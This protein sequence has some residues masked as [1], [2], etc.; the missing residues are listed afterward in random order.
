MA[1]W[2]RL[3]AH[4]DFEQ[5]KTIYSDPFSSV[6]RFVCAEWIEEQI[7]TDYSVDIGID[8]YVKERSDNFIHSLSNQLE[9][10]I[11]EE[12]YR[13][14]E[15]MLLKYRIENAIRMFRE[16]MCNS[17]ETYRHIRNVMQSEQQFLDPQFGF[18]D[19]EADNINEKLRKLNNDILMS[20]VKQKQFNHELENYTS[21]ELEKEIYANVSEY[22]GEEEQLRMRSLDSLNLKN[23]ELYLTIKQIAV[24]LM[25][26]LGFIITEIEYVENTVISHRLGRLQRY[27]AFVA[28]GER[29]PLSELRQTEEWYSTLGQRISATQS[30]IDDI[31]KIIDRFKITF[32]NMNANVDQFFTRITALQHNLIVSGFIVEVQP[33]QVIKTNTRFSATVRL[34]TAN[35]GIKLN[36]PTVTVSIL[37]GKILCSIQR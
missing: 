20:E 26:D 28:N 14:P 33:L 21:L 13:N 27:Q 34:L 22:T 6:V 5:F 23:N 17:I 25:H 31:R 35:M 16:N 32:D 9:K 2:N 18:I 12:K 8:P 19:A 30:S 37:S 10:E 29:F 3:S 4:P 24:D 1:R 15:Q 11:Q 7:R 36:K